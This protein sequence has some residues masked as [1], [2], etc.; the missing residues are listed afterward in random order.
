MRHVHERLQQDGLLQRLLAFAERQGLRLFVVGGTVRDVCLGR[1]SLDF[2]VAMAGDV[3]AVSRAFAREVSGA[4]VPLDPA[5]GEARVVYRKQGSIDFARF[6]GDDLTQDLRRRDFTINALACPLTTFLTTSTPELIDPCG[7]WD[8]LQACIVR[9]PSPQSFED[10]PLRMLR[11]F[12]LAASFDFTIDDLTLERMKPTVLRLADVAAERIHTEVLKLF[13]TPHSAPYVA[14]MGQLGL[15]DAVLPEVAATHGIT[16]NRYHHVDVF[17][18]SL[19]TYQSTE[20]VI[21]ALAS[22]FQ[23]ISDAVA[24]Y[25][26]AGEHLALLKWAALLHDIGKPAARRVDRRG[27]VSFP[28]HAGGGA[29]LWKEAGHRLKLSAARADYIQTLIAHH[30]RPRHLLTLASQGRLT[31]RVMHR[32]FRDLDE[33]VL[34]L[35]VLAVADALASRGPRTP[36][37]RPLALGRLCARVWEAYQTRIRPVLVGPRLLTG[38]DLQTVC[39]LEPGPRFKTLLESIELAHVEGHIRTRA[40]ALRLVEHLLGASMR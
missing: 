30:L 33:E 7:G 6:K 5:H 15:L 16:Q 29:L 3:M 20:A 4:Y 24:A 13:S 2:D 34:G 40:E 10:D 18:H 21:N 9:M 25:V 22:Y 12:R 14:T 39:G 11:A 17:E 27:R 32:L 1:A 26:R 36:S 19:L 28:G 37:N 23:P 35:F 31:L 8:D 38:D